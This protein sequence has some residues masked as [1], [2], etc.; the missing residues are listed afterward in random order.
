MSEIRSPM[1]G[2]V[3]EVLVAVGGQVSLGDEIILLESMKMEIP[4]AAECAG[5]IAE[6]RVSA[7]DSVQEGDLL[8]V[9]D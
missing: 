9:L 4:V 8:V 1:V 2:T 5:R 7:G 6:I 3:L